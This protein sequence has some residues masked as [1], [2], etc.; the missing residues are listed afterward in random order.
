MTRIL[1]LGGSGQVGQELN[2]LSKLAGITCIAPSS[3]KVDIAD[4]QAVLAC[5]E[6]SLPLDFVVNASAYTAVDK[7]ESEQELAYKVNAIGPGLL[8]KACAE[9]DIPLVHIS[10][11]YVFDGEAD[12]PYT[13][14]SPV[15]PIN[16]YG[17]SKLQGD[18]HV[19][20]NCPH[21]IILRTAWVFG[22]HGT[23]FVKT[24][25]KLGQTRTELNVVSDQ[26]GCPTEASYIASAIM[27]IIKLV[28]AGNIDSWGLYNFSGSGHTDWASFAAAIFSHVQRIDPD[29][30]TVKV[31]AISTAEYPVDAMRPAYTVLDCTKIMQAFGVVSEDWHSMLETSLPTIY[32]AV[33]DDLE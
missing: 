32:Q 22:S 3:S 9:N 29:Y 4:E 12:T 23:N 16:V 15:N 10:T 20:E 24:M 25:L 17:A 1:L 33:L 11:D 27:E 13:E 30:P 31:N 19:L 18:L 8:A 21:S 5:V 28:Q 6:N 2:R 14:T 7:A 26:I